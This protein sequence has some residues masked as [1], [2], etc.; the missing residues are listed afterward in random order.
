MMFEDLTK[1]QQLLIYM[2]NREC[3]DPE[4]PFIV[5][6]D[7]D[8]VIGYGITKNKNSLRN[9]LVQ[10]EN[11]HFIFGQRQKADNTVEWW[12]T[13]N[14]CYEARR[15]QNLCDGNDEELIQEDE[16]SISDDA[17]A[18]QIDGNV[19]SAFEN[20]NK[21]FDAMNKS[22]AALGMPAVKIPQVQTQNLVDIKKIHD[23]A[24]DE[25]VLRLAAGRVV[26]ETAIDRL[27]DGSKPR[28]EIIELLNDVL[29][30]AIDKTCTHAKAIREMTA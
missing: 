29:E 17:N 13:K 19:K 1:Q 7:A 11:K 8:D 10:L 20:M 9:M 28:S 12:M 16:D 15:L 30:N 18:Q 25:I 22:F 21:A 2:F 14:G 6:Y 5:S 3:S 26:L 27:K 4:Y 24:D 23:I